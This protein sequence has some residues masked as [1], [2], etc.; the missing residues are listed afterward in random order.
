MDIFGWTRQYVSCIF[1]RFNLLAFYSMLL[2]VSELFKT[3]TY[4]YIKLLSINYASNLVVSQHF[5]V[6]LILIYAVFFIVCRK[7]YYK[8]LVRDGKWSLGWMKDI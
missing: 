8:K 6:P 5:Q 2:K 7:L 4:I 1:L 3:S